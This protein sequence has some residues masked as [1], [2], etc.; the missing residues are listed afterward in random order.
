MNITLLP[1]GRD[2]H[3]VCRARPGWATKRGP[4]EPDYLVVVVDPVNFVWSYTQVIEGVSVVHKK[5]PQ[6]LSGEAWHHYR[7]TNING[8][9]CCHCYTETHLELIRSR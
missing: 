4:R 6:D 3:I 8:F 1:T 7:T 2:C 9:L 5:S